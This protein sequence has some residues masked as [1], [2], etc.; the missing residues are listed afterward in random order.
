MTVAL[1]VAAGSGERLG[2]GRPKALVELAGAP[3]MQWS[4]D[5]LQALQ[6]LSEIVVAL[7]AGTPAPPGVSTVEGGAVRSDSV[8]RALAAAGEGE[9]VLVHDAARPLLTPELAGA[10]IAALERD[11]Q[12][13]AA[14]AAAPVTDTVKRV[15]ADRM[16]T[17]TLDRSQ[18][19]A[20]Q[21]PQVFRRAALERALAVEDDELARATDDA[22]LIERSG[23][24]VI[25]VPWTHPNLKV[26][27]PLDLRV[28]ELL[29]QERH[30]AQS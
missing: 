10:V 13:D 19:W 14:I 6:G 9:I 4:I 21:T 11:E 30:K 20:V 25:V 23:G 8:R 26:T 29:L 16:V 17:E 12:A 18:L 3:L 24:R 2:A 15:D 5:A 27:T 28:A 1:I 7:P 22:W